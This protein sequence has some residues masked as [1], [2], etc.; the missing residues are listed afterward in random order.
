ML[1]SVT[2]VRTDVS[3]KRLSSVIRVTRISDLGTTLAVTS[4]RSTLRRKLYT[5]VVFLGSVFL[6]L[7]ADNIVHSTPTLFTLMMEAIRSSETSVLT[8]PHGVTFQ[9]TAFCIIISWCQPADLLIPS[10]W[11]MIGSYYPAKLSFRVNL[12]NCGFVSTCLIIASYQ[13]AE[14]YIPINVSNYSFV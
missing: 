13:P 1:R 14:L 6:L 3:E 8:K 5:T 12:Y 10:V 7:V 9:V 11:I 2:L 4:K